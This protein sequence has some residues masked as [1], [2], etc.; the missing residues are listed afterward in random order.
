MKNILVG[1]DLESNVDTILEYATKMAKPTHAKLWIVHVVR[2]AESQMGYTLSTQGLPGLLAS[3][4]GFYNQLFDL[5]T[6]RKVIATELHHE[7]AKLL[8]YSERIKA[9][10]IDVQGLLIEGDP[11]EAILS[12][13]KEKEVDLII[14][15]THGHGLMH[16]TIVGSISEQIIHK[17]TIPVLLIPTQ[18][19]N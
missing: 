11:S 15:G 12:E 6:T 5:E 16:K 10:Q 2:P 14:L 7:H 9:Q 3:G 13:A 18:Q 1:I 4:E 17:T 19:Q 8:K